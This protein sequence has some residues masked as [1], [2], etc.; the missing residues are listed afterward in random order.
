MAWYASVPTTYTVFEII[1][2]RWPKDGVPHDAAIN[3]PD[4]PRSRLV[5]SAAPGVNE[6]QG[7]KS[8]WQSLMARIKG[9]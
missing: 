4:P 6:S 1:A 3:H 2:N 8:Y 5:M 9:G 7:V